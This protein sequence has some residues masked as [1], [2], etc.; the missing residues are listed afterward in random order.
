MKLVRK[1]ADGHLPA[2]KLALFE[3]FGHEKTRL[4]RPIMRRNGSGTSDNGAQVRGAIARTIY[5][6]HSLT[7]VKCEV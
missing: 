7:T 2:R 6:F 3:P 1:P 5:T 4:Q